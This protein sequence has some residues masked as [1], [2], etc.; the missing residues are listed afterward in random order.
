MPGAGLERIRP[1]HRLVVSS[2]DGAKRNPGELAP[3]EKPGLRCAPS[4]LRLLSSLSRDS[5]RSYED[6]VKMDWCRDVF[7]PLSLAR[8]RACAALHLRGRIVPR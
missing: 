4:G 2:P 6:L 1:D 5:Y 7:R 8:L 3:H